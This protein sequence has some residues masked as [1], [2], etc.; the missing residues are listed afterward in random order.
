MPER[1]FN[2]AAGPA[3]LPYSVLEQ[4]AKDIVNFND[5]GI[6]LIEMSH[7]SAEFVAVADRTEPAARTDGHPGQLQGAVLQGGASSQFFMVPANL[8]GPDR[9]PP[10]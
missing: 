4:A 10:I 3:T 9:R 5:K 7:R 8:L 2:F 1:I 6:G